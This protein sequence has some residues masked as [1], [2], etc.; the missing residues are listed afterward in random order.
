MSD[1]SNSKYKEFHQDLAKQFGLTERDITFFR[2]SFYANGE[3]RKDIIEKIQEKLPHLKRG[4]S[5]RE[6]SYLKRLAFL[7]NCSDSDWT[8]LTKL[9]GLE[10]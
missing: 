10:N 5:Y 1:K 3:S 4:K 9:S 7:S 6:E 2:N 8:E